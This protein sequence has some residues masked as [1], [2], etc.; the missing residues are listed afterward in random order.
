LVGQRGGSACTTRMP[1]EDRGKYW[2]QNM[3]GVKDDRF[4]KGQ[5]S[6]VHKFLIR[7][8]I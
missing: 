1:E 7:R 8:I 5:I 4:K 3:V 6:F 2:V